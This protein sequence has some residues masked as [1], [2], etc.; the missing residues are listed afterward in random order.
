MSLQNQRKYILC[1]VSLFPSEAGVCIYSHYNRH[2][3]NHLLHRPGQPII[4]RFE[5]FDC[6]AFERFKD[7]YV[8]YVRKIQEIETS[9]SGPQHVHFTPEDLAWSS[10]GMPCVPP[11]FCRKDKHKLLKTQKE[12]IRSYVNAHYCE[13]MFY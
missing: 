11:P 2:D 3:N 6:P 8:D 13:S 7:A 12:I 10:N 5:E 9:V 4:P 1:N